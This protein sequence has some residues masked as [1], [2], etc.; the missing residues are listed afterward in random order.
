M[1][2]QAF[3]RDDARPALARCGTRARDLA[4]HRA[5]E[6]IA[7]AFED[8]DLRR[9][10]VIRAAAGDHDLTLALAAAR[11]AFPALARALVEQGTSPSGQ[12]RRALRRAAR[13]ASAVALLVLEATGAG[14][15]E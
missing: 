2:D 3:A 7:G 11:D 8:P 14:R 9:A 5:L 1:R 15:G 6:E 13:E 10:Q 4:T 12:G